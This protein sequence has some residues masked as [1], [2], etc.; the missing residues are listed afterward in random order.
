V[1]ILQ[2]PMEE[3]HAKNSA[4]L[5][6][7]SLPGSRK[8]VGEAFDDANLQALMTEPRCNLL[9]Y[10]PTAHPV[11]DESEP[12][13]TSQLADPSGLRLVVL[14]ATWR[15]SRKMLHLSPGLLRLPRLILAKVPAPRYAIRKAHKSGQL[16]TL[17]A[18]C[19][20]LAQV[21]GDAAKWEPLLNAFDSFVA[22]Q[23]AIRSD[24][25]FRR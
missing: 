11:H 22:Q 25:I 23:L 4:G 19:V 17:E 15:K 5:L 7:L 10:P 1:L 13:D 16:S 2:H 21:E 6:H 8:V 3:H 24:Y 14:D 9:L 20:A 18:T 12:L